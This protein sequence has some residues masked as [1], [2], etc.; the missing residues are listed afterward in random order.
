MKILY[1]LPHPADRLG[2]QQ[3]GHVIRATAITNALQSLGNEVIRVEAASEQGTQT[4]I[5]LYRKVVKRFL[6]R[7]LA[8]VMR[9]MARIRHGKRY[10]QRLI[11]AIRQ[12]S[13][14]VILETHIAFSLAGKI[15]SEQTG[16]PLVLDDCAPA[17][18]EEQQYGVGLKQAARN[19]HHEVT[20]HARLLVAVN[21]ALRRYLLDEG[22][23]P[24]KV[25]TVENGIDQK[26]F[27]PHVDGTF[28]RKQYSIPDDALVV[29]FV[30][31]FQPY[32]R[33]DLL[34]RAFQQ[35]KANPKVYLLLVGE[36]QTS[37]VCKALAAQLNLL[38]R[39]IFTGRISYEDV[40]SYVAAGDIT[41]M[42]ATNDYGNPM[43]V[44]EYMALGKAVVAPNQPTITEIATH[45]LNAYL[46]EP[47][48]IQ[49]MSSA[50][51][52][53]AVNP[54]LRR[55]LGTQGAQLAS[56]HTWEKRGGTMLS[57]IN[58]ILNQDSLYA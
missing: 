4:S 58:K 24:E 39:V 31:S 5:G 20:S 3:A 40:P 35:M 41:I 44:Y 37:Q 49:E 45:G 34:L 17:W 25:I 47:E 54:V 18:E 13:P 15:A 50:L 53:L 14:D 23:S 6:P 32:H 48:N 2:T 10:A 38:D 56:Q 21:N 26:Y 42:P 51:E 57:A 8:M 28:R 11:T 46:F 55:E 16:V 52:K 12:T 7:S 43:K 33:V 30:G 9:D 36:G 27:H 19:I 1:S 22:I 29:V